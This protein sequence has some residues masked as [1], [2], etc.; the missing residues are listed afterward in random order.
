MKINYTIFFTLLL[1][2]TSCVDKYDSGKNHPMQQTH[3][4]NLVSDKQ[5]LENSIR[6]QSN[7]DRNNWQKPREVIR[8]LGDLKGKTVAD[9]GAGYGYFSF[10]LLPYAGKVI[11]ID[12][13]KSALTQIDSLGKSLR[14][15]LQQKLETR[16]VGVDNPQL[17]DEEVDIVFMSNTYAY[18][19]NKVQYLQTVFKGMK[20]KGRIYIVDF[21][22][23]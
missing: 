17:E 8:L 22:M 9:I 14:D 4:Y 21:K 7:P 20:P 16:L 23:K 18:I 11:A 1:L 5:D 12:I 15:D 6:T 2:L 3:D 13:D 19:E 10:Q